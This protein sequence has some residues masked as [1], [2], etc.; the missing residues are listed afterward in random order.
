[1]RAAMSHISYFSIS[2]AVAALVLAFGCGDDVPGS[3]GGPDG[4][5]DGGTCG[6]FPP[7]RPDPSAGPAIE[8]VYA[9]KDVGF[10]GGPRVGY[11]LDGVCTVV[12][13]LVGSCSPAGTLEAVED[14]EDGRDA[15]FND[16]IFP[17]LEL[18]APDLESSIRDSQNVGVG[19]VLVRIREYNGAPNDEQVEITIA[20]TA[21]G[22][23]AGAAPDIVFGPAPSFTPTLADGST[24]PAPSWTGRDDVFWARSDFFATGDPDRPFVFDD[25]AYVS[26]N[27]LV[28]RLP[29]GS[30]L[31]FP[32]SDT[33][34][35]AQ[36]TGASLV[37]RLSDDLSQLQDVLIVGRWS[38]G[39]LLESAS[40]L[41]VCAGTPAGD[42]LES[43]AAN[44]ADVR[45]DENDRGDLT[46]DAVSV[47][48]SMQGFQASWPDAIAETP[49]ATGLCP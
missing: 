39:A 38:V 18:D 7:V 45:A 23:T 34:L 2:S 15:V 5:S 24:P 47:A 12:P 43:L 20:G 27:M 49:P 36:L 9:L 17:A 3:D 1:M 31:N 10:S 4:G 37:G 13:D 46:C 26:D 30:V 40:Q 14:G 21:F 29:D 25:N 44:V 19:A 11:D 16:Q 33:E 32:S 6:V 35:V 48:L 8:I 22:T 42:I 28:A 41:G